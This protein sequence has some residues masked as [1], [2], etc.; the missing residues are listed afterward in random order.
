MMP[1]ERPFSLLFYA[2]ILQTVSLRQVT[3][4]MDKWKFVNLHTCL[5]TKQ[6]RGKFFV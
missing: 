1:I 6:F 2:K 3:K 4:T 5:Q